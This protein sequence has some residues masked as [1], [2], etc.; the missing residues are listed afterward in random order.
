MQLPYTDKFSPVLRKAGFKKLKKHHHG[1]YPY[2]KNAGTDN[3]V[4][5]EVYD[6]DT[7]WYAWI[8]GKGIPSKGYPGG[9]FAHEPAELK[10][11]IE[12]IP[13]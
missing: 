8:V 2:G 7:H 12:S 4:Y 6:N 10:K 3:E 1:I 5:A 13:Q 11:L 9:Q